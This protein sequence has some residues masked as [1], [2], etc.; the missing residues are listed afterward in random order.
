V[1]VDPI[2]E[3]C[4]G[5]ANDR[6]VDLGQEVLQVL[7]N[8]TELQLSESGKD[9]A[10]LRRQTSNS[11]LGTRRWEFESNLKAFELGQ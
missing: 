6:S 5:G 4:G 9:S 10:Y 11:L 3:Y 2:E 8:A 1:K 7:V